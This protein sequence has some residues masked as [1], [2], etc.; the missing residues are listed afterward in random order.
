MT[1]ASH[2]WILTAHQPPDRFY[3]GGERIAA[4]RGAGPVRP[5]TPEDWVASVTTVFGHE[6]LGL[7]T[8]PD[9]TLLADVVRADPD[10][11]LGADHVARYG[12][13][14]AVLVKLLDA[15]QRLPVHVHPDVAFAQHHLGLGHG[16]TEAWIFLEPAPVWLGFMRDVSRDEVR[17]WVSGQ[18]V[19]AM[20]SAMHR[21][22]L[23]AGDAVLVPAGTPHAIGQGALI[24][25][26]QEPTDL[27]VLMEWKDFAIDGER[28]GHLGL[29]FDVAL[30]ALDRRGRDLI[31]VASWRESSAEDDGALLPGAGD[32]F[33]AERLRGDA[34][35]DAGYSVLVVERGVGALV[36]GQGQAI[37]LQ[38]GMTILTPH[39]AGD[40][41]LVD[42]GEL[43]VLRC[44]PPAA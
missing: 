19:D 12:D 16:K 26:L 41:T 7:S 4:F 20:L 14:P 29:G 10:G 3:A 17:S 40:L 30:E 31:E 28:D 33:R 42:H 22:Q 35:G 37:P 18:D 8:L 9:S 44:R 38:R 24:V 25:E 27:S 2:P 34:S 21:L 32:F 13:D 36:P 39:A 1:A 11:W 6:R 23:A 43:E 15:G 5:H